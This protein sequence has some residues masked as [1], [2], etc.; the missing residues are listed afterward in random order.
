M[1]DPFLARIGEVYRGEATL[2]A[3]NALELTVRMES[4]EADFV[5][6]YRRLM[7]LEKRRGA[8]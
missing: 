7:W 5:D 3:M 6:L 1:P 2:R 8:R 4:M